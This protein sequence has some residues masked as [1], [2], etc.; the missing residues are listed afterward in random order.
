MFWFLWALSASLCAAALAESNRIFRLDPQML[1]AWRATFATGL[2]ALAIPY[3]AWP[4]D[5]WFY[6]V[7]GMDGMVTAIGMI[8]FF[9]L[10]AKRSGRV[11]SM[12]LPLAAIGSYLMWWMLSP[13][14]R[15]DLTTN[16]G[17]V[18]TAVLSATIIFVAIQKVRDNDASWES[19][20]FVLPIGFLFGIFDA[21]TKYVMGEDYN[22][23][24]LALSYAF[25]ELLV[26][27]V[28]SWLA[29]IHHPIG[30]RPTG[31]FDGKLLW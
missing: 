25:L 16:P 3:M 19:F 30:G 29:T 5:K 24:A 15:P 4:A 23:Y 13:G 21:L 20:L 2:V 14:E 18:I 11:S 31:F 9:Y 8:M 1:N 27:A 10:A 12:I 28:V 17:R 22:I 7:A 26:C 6:I